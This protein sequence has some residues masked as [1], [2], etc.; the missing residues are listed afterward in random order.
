MDIS[1]K[2]EAVLRMLTALTPEQK[3]KVA[4][5]L[6]SRPEVRAVIDGIR[7]SKI[8]ELPG[9]EEESDAA[10][11]VADPHSKQTVQE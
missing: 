6:L 4:Q 1:S 11:R 8:N 9:S 2:K 3:I 7:L 5:R 10:N